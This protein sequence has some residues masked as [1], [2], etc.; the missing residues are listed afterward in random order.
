M[1]LKDMFQEVENELIRTEERM[2]DFREMNGGLQ[3]PNDSRGVLGA[4]LLPNMIGFVFGCAVARL[5]ECA[6]AGYIILGIIFAFVIGTLTANG[7]KGYPLGQSARMNAVLVG[8]VT[9]LFV[10]VY[11]LAG[12]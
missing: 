4:A 12:I 6:F 1:K 11:A 3:S 9:L 10:I 8:G 7:I 5:F 2:D